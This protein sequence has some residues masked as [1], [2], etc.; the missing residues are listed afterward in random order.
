MEWIL[1]SATTG[2]S[3]ADSNHLIYDQVFR[4]KRY[5]AGPVCY[6]VLQLATQVPPKEIIDKL[7]RFLVE[8]TTMIERFTALA[9]HIDA[10]LATKCSNALRSMQKKEEWEGAKA[11]LERFLGSLKEFCVT[12]KGK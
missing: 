11:E 4:Y 3:E 1:A 8:W 6:V 7:K 2:S 12:P 5:E 9:L 10:D